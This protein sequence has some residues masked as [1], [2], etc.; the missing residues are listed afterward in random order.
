MDILSVIYVGTG[1]FGVPILN[2]LALDKR[3]R[4]PFVITGQDKPSGRHLETHDS[5]IK[6]AALKNKLIV[7]QSGRATALK[8]KIIQANPD[9]LL[10]CSFGEIIPL[11]ILKIPK[12]GSINIHGSILPKYRGASPIQ[13]AL[14]S[15]DAITGITWTLMNQKMDAGEIIEKME[16]KIHPEDNYET[17]WPRMAESAAE[18]TFD[19]LINFAKTGRKTPQ[20]ESKATYC[21]KIKKQDGEIHARQESAVEIVNKIRA[22]TPWPG[23]FIFWNGKRLKIVQASASE[24]KISSGVMGES[25]VE[26]SEARPGEVKILEGKVLAIGT[27]KGV[28]LPMRVQMEGKRE[29]GVAEF[30]KGQKKILIS[31][32]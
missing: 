8:Q 31:N 5:A 30:L 6:Q 7:H 3:I 11:E 16:L 22:Y 4:I 15:G 2:T 23:C 29:M 24:Q 19:I 10:V 20:D 13:E 25:G 28:L 18:A 21:R 32:D 14:R 17:L 26:E 1:A 27:R 12:F 9:F